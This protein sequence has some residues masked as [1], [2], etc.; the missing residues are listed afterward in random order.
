VRNPLVAQMLQLGWGGK[1]STSQ[2]KQHQPGGA[3]SAASR[4]DTMLLR[5]GTHRVSTPRGNLGL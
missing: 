1:Q 5:A 4:S 2:G 3:A